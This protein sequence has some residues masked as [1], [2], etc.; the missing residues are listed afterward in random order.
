MAILPERSARGARSSGGPEYG[1][2]CGCSGSSD[3]PAE[4]RNQELEIDLCLGR[5]IDD[6]WIIAFLVLY[7]SVKNQMLFQGRVKAFY[8]I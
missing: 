5:H 8:V 2:H 3:G 6:R 4:N 7:M 1:G